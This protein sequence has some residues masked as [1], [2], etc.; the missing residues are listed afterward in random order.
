MKYYSSII[1]FGLLCF[2]IPVWGQLSPEQEA[3]PEIYAGKAS[4]HYGIP[5]YIISGLIKTYSQHGLSAKERIEFVDQLLI[6]FSSLQKNTQT[7]YQLT[8]REKQ[9][10]EITDN[11]EAENWLE[12]FQ[13]LVGWL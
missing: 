8:Q 1:L 10:L 6:E 12:W 7:N 4:I 11:Q 9:Q 3:S 13:Y 5:A 2:H